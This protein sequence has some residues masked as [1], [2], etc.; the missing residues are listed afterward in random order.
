MFKNYRCPFI[1]VFTFCLVF[2]R[3]NMFNCFER[4][5]VVVIFVFVVGPNDDVEIITKG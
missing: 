2:F 1:W 3:K 5:T 4:N